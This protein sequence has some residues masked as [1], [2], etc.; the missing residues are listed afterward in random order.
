[1]DWRFIGIQLDRSILRNHRER[2][3]DIGQLSRKAKNNSFEKRTLSKP[4]HVHAM[5]VRSHTDCPRVST[6][7][8]RKTPN[9]LNYSRR[10]ISASRNSSCKNQKRSASPAHKA[11]AVRKH[12][13][14]K[15][16]VSQMKVQPTLIH[17]WVNTV[18]NQA[19][20]AFNQSVL[21]TKQRKA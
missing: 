7:R 11:T 20:R 2:R 15:M 12:L 14:D 10:I 9:K 17:N 3:L 21:S 13:V 16:P 4:P 1:M 5:A 19:E 8:S 6:L 18:M